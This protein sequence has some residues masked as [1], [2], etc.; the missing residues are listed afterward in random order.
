MSDLLAQVRSMLA[1]TPD[2]WA[3]LGRVDEAVLTR[4][5]EPGEWSAL[6]ALQH[7]VD[8]EAGVFRV[9]VLAIRDGAPSFPGF[10]PDAEGHVDHPQG[11]VAELAAGL[12][13][14]RAESLAILDTLTEADLGKMSRHAEL[15]VVTM[16]ELLNEWAAHDAMHLVQAERA[17]MQAFIPGAGPWRSYFLEHDVAAGPK[18]RGPH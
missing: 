11:T 17:T 5:P 8:T 2:R 13:P 1:S 15:G 18:Q 14:M 10:N 6:Q 7:L 16:A 12:G 3:A 4:Q 9:R